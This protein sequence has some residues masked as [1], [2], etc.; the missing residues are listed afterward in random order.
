MAPD[1]KRFHRGERVGRGGR[2][3]LGGGGVWGRGE[4]TA[5]CGRERRK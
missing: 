3:E 5:V 2:G 4:T 1:A